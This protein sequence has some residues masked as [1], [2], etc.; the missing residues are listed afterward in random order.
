MVLDFGAGGLFGK[1][2]DEGRRKKEFYY[3][4]SPADISAS[5][6]DVEDVGRTASVFLVGANISLAIIPLQLPHGATI[7]GV[8]LYGTANDTY[9]IARKPV[10]AGSSTSFGSA[11]VGSAITISSANQQ[12]TL[13][14]NLNYGYLIYTDTIEATEQ[15]YGGVV[16]YTI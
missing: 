8:I 11:T 12:Y 5:Q 4:I 16:T 7:T 14:D 2:D 3:S 15:L 1:R 6:P 13:V 10:N 9:Y